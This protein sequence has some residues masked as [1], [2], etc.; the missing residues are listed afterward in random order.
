MKY[1]AGERI[2]VFKI[3]GFRLGIFSPHLFCDWNVIFNFNFIWNV[4]FTT[5]FDCFLS[6]KACNLPG[7][8][9]CTFLV[10]FSPDHKLVASSHVDHCINISRL[11]TGEHIQTLTGHP[12]S[13]WCVT[14]HPSSNEILAS[15][16][17][18][19][20]VRVWDL[21]VSQCCGYGC[22]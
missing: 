20:E 10:S 11:S 5:F 21:Q 9:R 2:L 17:L 18:G 12:R 15:G 7:T 19:G 3:M 8:P 14:F 4:L 1:L 13:P 16:C 22:C 6:K